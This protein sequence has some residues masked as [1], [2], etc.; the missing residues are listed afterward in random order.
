MVGNESCLRDSKRIRVDF[1]KAAFGGNYAAEWQV[2]C[3]FSYVPADKS[4][5]AAMALMIS[6]DQADRAEEALEMIEGQICALARQRTLGPKDLIDR[7]QKC[8]SA[9]LMKLDVF[10]KGN[11]DIIMGLVKEGVEV[12]VIGEDS[13]VKI[14]GF[15][16]VVSHRFVADVADI[17]CD[18]QERLIKC[19]DE[20]KEGMSTHLKSEANRIIPLAAGP[21]EMDFVMTPVMVSNRSENFMIE[22][23]FYCLIADKPKGME[24]PFNPPPDKNYIE[25]LEQGKKITSAVR[26]LADQQRNEAVAEDVT[27]KIMDLLNA[28]PDVEI[29]ISIHRPPAPQLMLAGHNAGDTAQQIL[30]ALE[31]KFPKHAIVNEE[32]IEET[33]ECQI[34]AQPD[35]E[36]SAE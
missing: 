12:T 30:E 18:P 31:N 22:L 20:I 9:E 2:L 8:S 21:A 26:I 14:P 5:C 36:S 29:S 3:Q 4:S 19:L 35:S 27:N 24:I 23:F 15:R 6:R 10:M 16:R 33:E 13:I 7:I 28:L 1:T 25:A 11:T 34:K 17:L 32:T